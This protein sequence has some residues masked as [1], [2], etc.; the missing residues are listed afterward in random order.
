L[1]I[2]TALSLTGASLVAQAPP[3]RPEPIIVDR[4]INRPDFRLSRNEILAHSTRSPHKHDDSRFH[5]F[6]PLTG[7]LVLTIEGE[8]PL[9]LEPWQPHLIP[10]GTVHGFRNENDVA[11]QFLEVFVQKTD[12]DAAASPLSDPNLRD[13]WAS[14]TSAPRRPT[15]GP[16]E[17]QRPSEER[18]RPTVEDQAR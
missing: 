3:A 15:A 1:S 17:R 7:P 14:L 6:V 13:A 8:A 18:P 4:L 2:G 16:A 9:R 10:G 11:V 5:V 12:S